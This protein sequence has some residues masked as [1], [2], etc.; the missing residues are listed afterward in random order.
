MT[1][2]RAQGS[3]ARPV[4][5]ADGTWAC[6]V[7]F[8]DSEGN[9]TSDWVHAPTEREAFNL[10][11][12]ALARNLRE[13]EEI[14][15]GIRIA[16][17]VAAPD[18]ETLAARC[19]RDFLPTRQ[20]KGQQIRTLT[21]VKNWWLPEVGGRP[22][23]EIGRADL[24]RVLAVRRRLGASASTCNRA[25]AALSVV[26]QFASEAEIVR[27]NPCR[28]LRQ[29][30]GRK[31]PRYLSGDEA[32][33][34]IVAADPEWRAFFATALYTGLRLG[35][36]AAMRWQDVDLGRGLIHVRGSNDQSAPK[37]GHQRT[38]AIMAQLRPH[39]EAR[40]ELA[41]EPVHLVFVGGRRRGSGRSDPTRDRIVAP[42]KAL[43]RALKAAGIERH[44]SMHDLRH[45]FATLYL[46]A[47]AT[48]RD[49][50][51]ALGHSSLVMSSRYAH[52]TGKHREIV[53]PTAKPDD[54]PRGFDLH[55][56]KPKASDEP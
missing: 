28:G 49:L 6:R 36:I 15:A 12:L 53:L 46:D 34:L 7:R 2:R 18:L 31:V 13:Q 41:H 24:R 16:T 56:K 4:Q 3:V 44:L 33:R 47:G 5:R 35:E 10:G 23:T 42:R 26:F 51:E 27:D 14:R 17:P 25:L 55:K 22:I 43:S 19:A 40:A 1:A 32:A 37:S 50:Q 39:L 8:A 38:V 9:R 21:L 20:A 29:T 30:E 52:A 54:E 45:T 11:H 48:P